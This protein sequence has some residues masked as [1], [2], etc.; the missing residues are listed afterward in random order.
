MGKHKGTG[1]TDA[2]KPFKDL[3]PKQKADEFD[4]S[5]QDPKGYAERNFGGGQSTGEKYD[6]ART[7]Q[8]DQQNKRK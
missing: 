6:A 7:E 1:N 8:R 2:G 3:T 4:A 5:H